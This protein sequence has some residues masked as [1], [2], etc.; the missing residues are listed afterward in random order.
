M[1]YSWSAFVYVNHP[2][3]SLLIV[4]RIGISVGGGLVDARED[5][6]RTDDTPCRATT[7]RLGQG[8]VEPILL[9]RAHHAAAGVVLDLVDVVRVPV[10]IGDRAVVLTSVKH[11]EINELANLE[12]PP[13][14]KI[15]VHI[16]LPSRMS[17][18]PQ[19]QFKQ[20][21]FT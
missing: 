4:K 3:L 11:D 7:L 20:S 8:I 18:V 6:L 5:S 21:I 9:M 14:A 16:D 2:L 15:V 19:F 1:H 12:G 13:D 17:D 10:E